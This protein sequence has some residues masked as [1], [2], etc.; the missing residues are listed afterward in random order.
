MHETAGEGQGKTGREEKECSLTAV[1]LICV[2][3]S[4]T[5]RLSPERKSDASPAES[6]RC[7]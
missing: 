3:N 7:P 6:P 1:S 2:S 5:V 4:H